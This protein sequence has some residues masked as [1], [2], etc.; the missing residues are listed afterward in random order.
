MEPVDDAEEDG[1]EDAEQ[2]SAWGPAHETGEA[3]D[4]KERLEKHTDITYGQDEEHP[5]VFLKVHAL[6]LA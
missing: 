4:S 5:E 3:G 6:G 1:T 2:D